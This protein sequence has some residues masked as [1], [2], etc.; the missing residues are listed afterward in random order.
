MTKAQ[1]KEVFAAFRTGAAER[2]EYLTL[3]SESPGWSDVTAIIDDG[4]AAALN[5]IDRLPA[6]GE[7]G[8]R[9]LRPGER[10]HLDVF[11]PGW[12]E[13]GYRP[14][15]ASEIDGGR[16]ADIEWQFQ[17]INPGG[18]RVASFC[19]RASALDDGAFYRTK[20]PLPL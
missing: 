16:H 11:A 8:F 15:L 2:M 4:V 19:D 6:D 1:L 18:W 5:A 3:Y 17:P 12:F 9:S 10:W 13:G 7:F 20:R 14:L